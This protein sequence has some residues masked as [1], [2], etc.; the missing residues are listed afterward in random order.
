MEVTGFVELCKDV[1]ARKG[2]NIMYGRIMGYIAVHECR[3]YAD[4]IITIITATH[5]GRDLFE[6]SVRY[7][8]EGDREI[9]NPCIMIIDDDMIRYHGDWRHAEAH[10]KT[11]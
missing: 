6:V 11:L 7:K 8:V 3:K 5:N 1:L 9:E 10:I 2:E 4:D